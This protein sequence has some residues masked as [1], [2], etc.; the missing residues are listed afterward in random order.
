MHRKVINIVQEDL[1]RIISTNLPWENLKNSIILISGANGFL[2][3]YMVE[4]LLYL[5]SVKNLNIKVVGLVRNRNKALDRFS[6]YQDRKDLKLL[7]QDVCNP[8]EYIESIDYIIHAASQASPKY[9]ATDPV[10]TLNANLLGTHNLLT[11]ANKHQLK[12]F[13]FFSSGEVY[14]QVDD[15][16]IPTQE[17]QYG[18]LDPT[19]LRSCYAESKRMAETMCISWFHQYGLPTK[20]VRPFHTYGFGMSLDDGRVYAD[21]VADIIRNRDIQIKSDGTA[22][23]AFCYI[24][25]ATIGFFTVLLKGENGQAYNI[26]ND[27]CEIS[28]LDLAN[29][30][31]NLFPDKNLKVIKNMVANDREYLKSNVSRNCPDITKAGNLGWK[32]TTSIE[33]GFTRTICSFLNY[34]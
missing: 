4:T 28:I 5:N 27:Q 22:T 23:R 8:I 32:P 7:V 24:A 21:F 19:N 26:G 31:I 25:D 15:S 11:L 34:I 12:G 14:G 10:G 3:A 9:Y 30:F 29:R 2:P 13:L 18:Y 33:D 16:Q 20:I 1:A 6:N 17:D